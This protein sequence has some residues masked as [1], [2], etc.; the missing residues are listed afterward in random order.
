MV[1]LSPQLNREEPSASHQHRCP[2]EG[3]E[4]CTRD[5]SKHDGLR[6]FKADA[7]QYF[8]WAKYDTLKF[9]NLRMQLLWMK[10]NNNQ[11]VWIRCCFGRWFE[12]VSDVRFYLNCFDYIQIAIYTI[13]FV[14]IIFI[15]KYSHSYFLTKVSRLKVCQVFN[16]DLD[17]RV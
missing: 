4:A 10:E 6:H 15:M 8:R 2:L 13:L 5:F 3:S 7:K 12:L 1:L 9:I 11:V 16:F 14:I 17:N